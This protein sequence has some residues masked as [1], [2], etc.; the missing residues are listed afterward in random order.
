MCSACS[1]INL[2][3][4]A[5]LSEKIQIIEGLEAVLVRSK[6]DQEV[7]QNQCASS[8]QKLNQALVHVVWLELQLRYSET[9]KIEACSKVSQLE[10][11]NNELE[12]YASEADALRKELE[13]ASSILD[14]ANEQVDMLKCAIIENEREISLLRSA[15]Q[16]GSKKHQETA[17]EN[18]MEL[19]GCDKAT[20]QLSCS[21][22]ELTE[23][24]TDIDPTPKN[25]LQRSK[26]LSVKEKHRSTGRLFSWVRR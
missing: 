21:M 22:E 26:F 15:A 20:M 24:S 8:E 4:E 5:E 3:L 11:V 23:L 18:L 25:F 14:R 1:K 9:A 12:M 17:F 10:L 7:V 16:F 2:Y 19:R 6:V 13:S